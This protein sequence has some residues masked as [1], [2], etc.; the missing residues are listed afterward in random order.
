MLIFQGISP[1]QAPRTGRAVA[2]GN[3]DGVHLGH[4]ALIRTAV[5]IAKREGLD[6]TVVTFEPHPKAYFRPDQAPGKIQ[7]LRGK[8]AALAQMGV[9][10][11]RILKFRKSLAEMTADQFMQQVLHDSLQ[12]K[13]IVI[14]DDFHFG[15]KRQGDAA[16]LAGAQSRFGWQLHQLHTV[17]VDHHRASSSS[18]RTALAA[19][20][21]EQA[22]V[23]MG[24]PYTLHG[25][26]IHGKRIGRSIGFP[27]LN[28][29]VHRELLASGVF[30][31]SV[32]GLGSAP[33]AA[34]AS[35]G[36]RPTVESEGRLL[37]EVHLFD[38]QGDA[39]GRL[40]CVT[41]HEKIRNE[42]RYNTIDDMTRQI[43][44]DAQAA[45]QYFSHHAH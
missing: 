24:R 13:A 6:S 5:E 28:I 15:A 21:M 9:D 26:V 44:S 11:M 42:I 34:V 41:L 22:R 30:V 14:G 12:A 18:L 1:S 27:T 37:L 7:G 3:F 32:E 43:E 39:Y 36:R 10:E 17:H 35:L 8:A 16:M 23:M 33:I 29:P 31:A 2:I 38:W 20:D 19:G 25:H 45:R 40:V 4:Q